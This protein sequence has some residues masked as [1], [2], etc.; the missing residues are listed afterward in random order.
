MQHRFFLFCPRCHAASYCKADATVD[1]PFLLIF[2]TEGAR[3]IKVSCPVLTKLK[4]GPHGGF[5]PG[6]L[7]RYLSLLRSAI[8]GIVSPANSTF[9]LMCQIE[10]SIER[11]VFS[12]SASFDSNASYHAVK[13]ALSDLQFFLS[14]MRGKAIGIDMRPCHLQLWFD[15]FLVTAESLSIPRRNAISSISVVSFQFIADTVIDGEVISY[16]AGLDRQVEMILISKIF[17]SIQP[18][19]IHFRLTG[20]SSHSTKVFILIGVIGIT[21]LVIDG[22]SGDHAFR[23]DLVIAD[24]HTP[25]LVCDVDPCR[26]IAIFSSIGTCPE[27]LF[28]HIPAQEITSIDEVIG[29]RTPRHE[30]TGDRSPCPFHDS[31]L[32]ITADIDQMSVILPFSI[33]LST[34][35]HIPHEA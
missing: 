5:D 23:I 33:L 11:A 18:D 7:H 34:E 24:L 4:C 28:F 15:I 12:I 30:R 16:T 3:Y 14:A 20:I 2:T 26:I 17:G 22:R 29:I 8:I 27:T 32:K 19:T 25:V 31:G 21:G 13:T 10:L 1:F 6:I 35:S 9:E